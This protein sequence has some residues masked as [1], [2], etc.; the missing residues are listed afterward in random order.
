MLA[1][2]VKTLYFGIISPHV[3]KSKTF[4]G[5]WIP[6]CEFRISDTGFQLVEL[7]YW[8]PIVSGILDSFSCIPDSKA[9]D[10]GSTSKVF[11]EIPQAKMS[12]IPESVFPYIGRNCLRTR[13]SPR[14]SY[15][16][17]Y[18]P[19]FVTGANM[20]TQAVF[21]RRLRMKLNVSH[22]SRF[23]FLKRTKLDQAP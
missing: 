12:Q 20:S 13:T 7:G 6:E 14:S 11:L 10:S 4:L 18:L 9:Q 19:F 8:I 21:G 17:Y 3:R 16:I 22:K 2:G 5:F 15:F 1:T 23:F